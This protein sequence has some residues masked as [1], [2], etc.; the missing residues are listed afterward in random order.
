MYS[1]TLLARDISATP[2]LMGVTD[3]LAEAQRLCEPHLESRRAFLGYVEAVRPAMTVAGLDAC[4]VR[5]GH[6][7]VGRLGSAARVSWRA[8]TGT[9]GYFGSKRPVSRYLG[10]HRPH[11]TALVLT[12]NIVAW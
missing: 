8:R 12:R 4:Y 3:S 1:W 11:G 10:R 9:R 5:T 7:W 2:Y 6:A